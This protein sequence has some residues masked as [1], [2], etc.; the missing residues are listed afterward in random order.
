M[1]IGHRKEG[2]CA[3]MRMVS[4]NGRTTPWRIMVT[5]FMRV[6][7]AAVTVGLVSCSGGKDDGL[8]LTENPSATFFEQTMEPSLPLAAAEWS[9]TQEY[10]NSTGLAQVKAAEGYA[11]RT[12]G[13]PGGEGVRIAI[14]DSGIDVSHPDLGNVFGMSWSAGDE[15]LVGDF[16]GTFV[17]GIAGA[18]RTQTGDPD[19][20][21][22]LAYRATLLN[23]QAARPSV[24]AS[25][26]SIFFR[27]SDV[28]D[29]LNLAS[30]IGP[31]STAMES[32]II[33]LSLGGFSDSDSTFDVLRTAM[34][35]VAAEGK[36]M[37]IAAGN[38]GNDTDPSKKLQPIYPAAYADDS[39]IAGL[40]IVVGNL[41][42]DGVAAASSNLCGDTKNYCLFAP[43]TKIQST[44]AGGNYGIG[45]GTSFAAPYVSG[46]AAVV[47]A[48]FPGVSNEDV[49]DRL[50]LTAED[51]GDPGVDDT[52]GRGLLDLEAAMSPVGQ[53]GLT[54]GPSVTSAA[55]SGS[56]S[57]F[58]LGTAWS[59]GEHGKNLL[60]K[61]IGFD[62]MGFPF[63]IDLNQQVTTRTR[64]SNL[65]GFIGA[66]HA[67]ST[68]ISLPHADLSVVSSDSLDDDLGLRSEYLTHSKGNRARSTG[69][70]LSLST[71][72]DANIT[73]FAL[74]NGSSSTKLSLQQ[75]LADHQVHFVQ[76]MATVGPFD[77]LSGLVSGGGFIVTPL[78]GLK[79]GLSTFASFND[80]QAT[81]K[82][83]QK[84]EMVKELFG[85][86]ELRLGWGFIQEQGGFM[87]AKSSGVFGQTL[88]SRS[89]FAD[90]SLVA[91]ITEKTTWF[92]FYSRGHSSV[93]SDHRSFLS[94]LSAVKAEAFGTGLATR[95]LSVSGDSFSWMIG[96]PLR[97]DRAKGTLTVP[98][99]RTPDG[100]VII[101]QQQIDLAPSSREII[102]EATYHLPLDSRGT[103]DIS[104]G[105]FASLNPGHDADMSPEFGV[106]I[107]Y[108]WQF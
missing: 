81:E 94:D 46:A 76:P 47:K 48:G 29:A 8:R 86:L 103:Q 88:K 32:D 25:T 39:G 100:E 43:G 98:I 9:S 16:H 28:V 2:G 72:L 74:H 105:G 80:D 101:E 79:V 5:L 92:S 107:R 50:L 34:R 59:M 30:G 21:H 10:K 102:S 35:A 45:T 23:F 17:A 37:V 85:S 99:G 20:M 97:G 58:D 41:T 24:T 38:E 19:D 57:S 53:V 64:A 93:T 96:Q 108:R 33:N 6:V 91:A 77:R 54:I 49:V 44:L 51:L 60:E 104:V 27:N 18:S 7:L 31:S 95:D 13:L 26:G 61:A 83:V 67:S 65:G 40:A 22:G 36:I 84:I 52:Y 71:D 78:E 56:Q 42:K 73:F 63:P 68:T 82:T 15:A 4:R 70:Q 12:G 106:G 89:Q 75:A 87:G 90:L 55:I 69:S 11:N 14:I 62:E 3:I 66:A 1:R